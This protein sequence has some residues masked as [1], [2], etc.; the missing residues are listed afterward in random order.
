MLSIKQAVSKINTIKT[1]GAKLDSLIH[2]VAC[3]AIY[4]VNVHGNTEVVNKLLG[5]MNKSSRK[6][7]LTLWLL[8]H[9]KLK[10]VP[11]SSGLEYS[12]KRTLWLSRGVEG[13]PEQIQEKAQATPFYDY[14]KEVAPTTPM[15]HFD[16]RIT[17]II[18]TLQDETK[19]VE[20]KKGVTATAT[21]RKELAEKLRGLIGMVEYEVAPL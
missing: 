18:E 15:F 12:S 20:I 9:A 21:E 6:E 2:E 14:T 8:D 5:A 16:T 7:A 1:A 3:S 13:T 4:H 19:P 10:R 11:N 17:S